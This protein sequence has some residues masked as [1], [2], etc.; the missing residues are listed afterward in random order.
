MLLSK[1]CVYGL[2]ASIYLALHTDREYVPI[3]EVSE[4]L[5]ISFHFLTKIL[6][7]LTQKGL[8]TSYRGPNGGVTLAK[9]AREMIIY[10]IVSAIDGDAVFT[11]C[12]LSLPGCGN[13]TPCPMHDSWALIRN[14]I[15]TLFLTTSLADLAKGVRENNLRLVDLQ[16]IIGSMNGTATA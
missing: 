16:Q 5:Q 12:I 3:S 13:Q 7:Q 9:P 10:D 11:G 2:R 6:Q 8:L 4:K 15:R 1:S 14:K